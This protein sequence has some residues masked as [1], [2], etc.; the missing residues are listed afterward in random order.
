MKNT[1]K[2]RTILVIDDD[3]PML[4]GLKTLLERNS[5]KVNAC[6]SSLSG[7]KVAEELLPDLIVCDIMMPFMDG[8]K[9]KEK[10]SSSPITHDI[11][12]IFL[13]ARTSLADKLSGFASGAEDYITKPFDQDELIARINAIIRR[14]DTKLQNVEREINY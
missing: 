6:E 10:L 11:P 5:Y 8:F 13:S 14:Q 4:F 9:V 3:L 2:P 12:F 7:V 1:N